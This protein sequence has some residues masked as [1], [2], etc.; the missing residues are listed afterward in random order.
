MSTGDTESSD[1]VCATCGIAAI[2]DI[3]L[4]DCDG[5]CDLMKYC[6]DDCQTNHREQHKE[7]CK[8]RKAELRD[9]DL[10]TQNDSSYLG[11]CPICCLPLSLHMSKSTLMSCCSKIICDGCNYAN[12]KR[13]NEQGL[14]NRCPF[15]REPMAKSE[16]EDD[17]NMME[18][19]KKNDPVAMTHMGKKHRNER[20]FGKALE[21]YTKAAELGDVDAHFCLGTM[22]YEGNGVE[23]DEEKA[24]YHF[25]QAA[26]GGHI[27]ARGLLATHEEH[28][29]RLER[30]AKHFII[31]ATSDVICR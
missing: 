8:R 17:R 20:E 4:K 19:V 13:E 16:E 15:C 24:V 27:V 9:K 6:S 11:E 12:Q 30:A 7:E 31:N 26:I 3:K 10:F 25:E 23:K 5:G 21:Y 2:D 28:N 22:Y 1:E 18:R 14:E 29:G